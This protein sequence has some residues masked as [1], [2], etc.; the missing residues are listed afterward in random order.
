MDF[1][2]SKA[3]KL[4]QQ[5]AREF[6]QRSCPLAKVRALMATETGFDQELWSGIADQGWVGMTLPEDRGG[7][8]LSVVDLAAVAEEV[9]RAC[10]P[11]PFWSNV[12][13]TLLL[14][15]AG[16]DGRRAELEALAE[17]RA[18][19]TVALTEE[20]GDW[21]P[22]Q[23]SVRA[24]RKQDNLILSGTKAFVGDAAVADRILV[25]TH[26]GDELA[27]VPVAKGANGLALKA[28][29]SIDATRKWYRV[30]LDN[31][32]APAAQ[33]I[34]GKGA[35]EALE[36]SMGAV[37]AALCAEATGVM[38]WILDT[39]VEYA[40]TRRQFDQPIG[41]FQAVQ[42]QCAEMLMYTESARSAAYYA[43][44]AVAERDPGW[45]R[46][47]AIAKAY[48]SDAGREVGNRGCQVHGGIGFTWEHDLHLF[49]KRIKSFEAL[50]GDGAYHREVVGALEF[51]T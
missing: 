20:S 41:S 32:E 10:V 31:V 30:T 7:L 28:M 45:K 51:A 37:T 29:A 5:S 18:H 15:Y 19:A 50:F 47:V 24:E 34:T 39:A 9:G 27:I 33:A 42:H 36:L 4:L 38:Q 26:L 40:K 46:A 23:V 3:Q 22:A 14:Q 11:G 49:Y 13:A 6:F 48:C 43:A 17:G 8:G 16:A 25:V 44:W 21:D 2:L 1:E 12:W 35:T